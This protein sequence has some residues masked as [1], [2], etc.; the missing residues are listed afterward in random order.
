M[1]DLLPKIARS[2]QIRHGIMILEA[3]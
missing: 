3:E 2:L 1:N